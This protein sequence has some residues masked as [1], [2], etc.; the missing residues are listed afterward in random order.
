MNLRTCTWL[1]YAVMMAGCTWAITVVDTDV[2][3]KKGLPEQPTSET[4]PDP[5]LIDKPENESEKTLRD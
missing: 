1:G 5:Q 4:D 3:H 2:T